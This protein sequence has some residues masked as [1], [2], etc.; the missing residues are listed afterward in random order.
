MQQISLLPKYIKLISRGVY[1]MCIC[2]C[3]CR[4]SCN[5]PLTKVHYLYL[6]CFNFSS[7]LINYG[8]STGL[9]CVS[10][11]AQIG[12]DLPNYKFELYLQQQNNFMNVQNIT[13][14][15]TTDQCKVWININY[16]AKLP[17]ANTIWWHCQP[18]VKTTLFRKMIPA[19]MW[20]CVV[21]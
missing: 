20:H 6:H 18:S 14:N 11:Y 5:R 19:S 8:Q 10:F 1:L 7:F 3:E 17:K 12:A 21:R 4:L 13:L 16:T 15:D 2:V 9:Q